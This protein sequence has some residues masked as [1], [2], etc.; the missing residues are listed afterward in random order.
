LLLIYI[1]ILF[2]GA[3]THNTLHIPLRLNAQK[4]AEIHYASVSNQYVRCPDDVTYPH[5]SEDR[6]RE[7]I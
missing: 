5:V 6:R 2:A 4:T 1:I 3:L 7:K